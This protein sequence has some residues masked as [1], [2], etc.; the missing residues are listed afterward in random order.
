MRKHLWKAV[1]VAAVLVMTVSAL[2]ALAQEKKSK[3]AP[4]GKAA[5]QTTPG[6]ACTVARD[7]Q[8][9]MPG[10]GMKGDM[11]K[12]R[13]SDARLRHEGRRA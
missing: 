7:G 12:G 6:C 9:G 13:C 11:G 10:C 3:P 4:A 5:E 1:A 2:T 8:G